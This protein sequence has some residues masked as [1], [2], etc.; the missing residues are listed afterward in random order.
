M[1]NNMQNLKHKVAIIGCGRLGQQYGMAY[2]AYPDTEI[3]AIAEYNPERRKAV[4]QRFGVKNLY[5]DAESMLKEIVPDIAA[6]VTPTKWM[7]ESVIACAQAGVKGVSTDKPLAAKLSDA[8]EMVEACESRGVIFAGGNL[9]RSHNHVQEAA[10][11]LR[12]GR[13]GDIKGAVIANMGERISGGGVQ[14][15]SAIRLFMDSEV[16]EVMCWGNPAETINTDDDLMG[17]SGVFNMGNKISVPFYEGRITDATKSAINHSTGETSNRNM[18]IDVWTDDSLIRW[19]WD[20]IEIFQGFDNS[21]KRKVLNLDFTDWKW[22]QFGYLTSTIR[23]L[24]NTIETG[25]KLAISGHDLRQ[26]L[27]VAI[28]MKLSAQLGNAPVKLPLSDRSHTMIP[29][30]GRWLGKDLIGNPQSFEDA[31]GVTK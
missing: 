3:V 12:E 29:A 23:S 9:A 18:G 28:A 21:G 30:S 1:N 6:V 26:A 31:L 14:S 27:E 20:M 16:E 22:Q 7:K 5:T 19:F 2:T 4:G 13:F 15:I 24:I 17:S 11:W 25:S 10:K 8:D